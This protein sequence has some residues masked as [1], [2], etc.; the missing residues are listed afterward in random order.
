MSDKK[1]SAEKSVKDTG[2]KSGKKSGLGSTLIRWFRRMFFGG[3]RELAREMEN[4]DHSQDTEE[5]VS[6]TK[7]IIRGFMERKLA[8]AALIFVI[9]MFLFVMIGPLFITNYYDA[10]TET[11][12]Q[13]IPPTMSMLSVPGELEKDVKMI[14]SY[15]SWSIGLSNAGKVYIWGSTSLGTTGKDMSDIPEEVQNAN[16]QWIAAGIDHAIAIDDKGKVYAWGANT[17]GQYGYYDPK[18]F[19]DFVTM[20]DEVLNGTIDVAN[21]KKVTCGYQASAILMND[22]TAYVWGNKKAYSNLKSFVGRDDL[23]DIDFTL[24]Y[25]VGLIEE[26]DLLFTGKKGL[27]DQYKSNVGEKAMPAKDYL[28]GRK[29]VEIA[30]TSKT[31]ALL[32]ND[33]SICY[34]GDFL[35]SWS[36]KMPTLPEDEDFSEIVSGTYHYSG[37]TNKGNVYSWGGNI[38]DQTKVPSNMKG[39]TKLFAGGYQ[40][41]AVNENHELVGKWGLSG[42]L[43]GTDTNG[44]NIFYRIIEGGRMTMTIGAVAVIISS[45]IGIIIG[46]LSG[47]FGGAVDMILMR[48]AEIFSAIPFLPF[49]MVLS[50]VTA[51]M[52]IEEDVKIFMMMVILGVLTWP[53]LARMVR[54]QVLVA[55]ENEYVTA[56]KAM[57]VKESK[58]AFKHI[59]PNIVSVIF[60]SLTLDFATCMLTESSLSYLGFGVTYPRPT[61]GNMLNGANNATII[62]N[63]WWEWVFTS[64]FLSLTCICINIIGDALRD[65]MDPRSDRDK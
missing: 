26:S 3:S 41:Y 15:G 56:A 17:L 29:V 37:L 53:G 19:P 47:Y 31:V 27:Y 1:K 20:P 63:F 6:P 9:A 16:I 49:A 62:K 65:V 34:V 10:Y 44:A 24:N 61:W 43:F 48:V 21:I 57:G 54:G 40:T 12:Q 50:A 58:I 39:V 18:E 23:I 64:L 51:T 55:R 36:D 38:L 5:I 8:V 11:T 52:N 46:I 4:T 7:R 45:V 2:N 42:Y 35:E 30:A 32:L 33:G 59:L 25:V 22:G 60:V 13:N 14:D 28:N